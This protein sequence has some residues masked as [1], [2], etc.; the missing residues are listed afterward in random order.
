MQ[1]GRSR[2]AWPPCF[3]A[4]AAPAGRLGTTE[5]NGFYQPMRYTAVDGDTWEGI[6]AHFRMTPEILR[7]VTASTQPMMRPFSRG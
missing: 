5:M 6:A 7:L 4:S 2:P 3:I 1:D